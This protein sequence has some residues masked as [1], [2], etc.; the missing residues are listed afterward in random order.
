MGVCGNYGKSFNFQ[1]LDMQGKSTT[2]TSFCRSFGNL[3]WC[4]F[5][6]A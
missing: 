5:F 3:Q 1:A 2:F 6:D 4:L